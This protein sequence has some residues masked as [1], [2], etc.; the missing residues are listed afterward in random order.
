MID[1]P[2]LPP[3]P[4]PR[5]YHPSAGA[6][7][8]P[9]QNSCRR[10]PGRGG[11]LA[12]QLLPSP[13]AAFTKYGRFFLPPVF[14]TQA[15]AQERS[16]PDAEVSCALLRP[17]PPAPSPPPPS[18]LG[19]APTGRGGMPPPRLASIPGS[20]TSILRCWRIPRHLKSK[21]LGFWGEREAREEKGAQCWYP[22]S[23]ML[24]PAWHTWVGGVLGAWWHGVWIQVRGV[25]ANLGYPRGCWPGTQGVMEARSHWATK[26]QR[27]PKN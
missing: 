16:F 7:A 17:P 5:C 25:Q 9:L 27:A 18:T 22:L 26:S 4:P 15:A 8:E 13:R 21:L 11:G 19:P 20:P 6:F 3:H 14:G 24:V 12:G 10:R 2:D 23:L 1:H